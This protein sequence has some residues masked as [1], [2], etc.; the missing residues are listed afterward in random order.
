L[1]ELPDKTSGLDVIEIPR[2]ELEGFQFPFQKEAI[3]PVEADSQSVR[4]QSRGRMVGTETTAFDF[5]SQKVL[6]T[7]G[8]R[9]TSRASS[10]APASTA[11]SARRFN[12]DTEPYHTP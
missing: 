3:G 9:G 4:A 11:G 6:I 8:L 7:P 1:Q 5:E 2:Q 10:A 12:S